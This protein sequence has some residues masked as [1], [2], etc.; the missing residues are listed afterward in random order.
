MLK[1]VKP[2]KETTRIIKMKKRIRMGV[3]HKHNSG[4]ELH[5]GIS[6][7]V[8]RP[9]QSNKELSGSSARTAGYP[10]EKRS[11]QM[12]ALLFCA[13]GDGNPVCPPS[14][15]ICRKCLDKISSNLEKMIADMEQKKSK[16][17]VD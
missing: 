9:K 10:V 14:K 6:S 3:A 8:R 5:G 4:V 15:V 2:V 11:F 1:D 7:S 16:A 13:N 17:K 12:K